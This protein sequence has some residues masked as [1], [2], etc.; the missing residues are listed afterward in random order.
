MFFG[1]EY[2]ILGRLPRRT[3]NVKQTFRIQVYQKKVTEISRI[4]RICSHRFPT[5]PPFPYF[6]FFNVCAFLHI[7]IFNKIFNTEKNISKHCSTYLLYRAI[8]LLKVTRDLETYLIFLEFVLK[9][10]YKTDQRQHIT[11]PSFF[12]T[13]VFGEMSLG[14]ERI[15]ENKLCSTTFPFAETFHFPLDSGQA[16]I[17]HFKIKTDLNKYSICLR[18]FIY[19]LPF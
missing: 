14:R 1:S 3:I 13:L 6:F 15:V 10:I 12:V 7:M 2:Y 17:K 9:K 11:L 18:N 8:N 19:K 5:V 16:E 4:Y